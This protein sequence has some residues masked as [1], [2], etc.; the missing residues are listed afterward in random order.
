MSGAGGPVGEA[1]ATLRVLTYNVRSLRDDRCAVAALIRAARPDVA[2]IQEAPRFAHGRSRC[3][4]LAAGAGLVVVTGG[5]RAG[6]ML[7]LARLEVEVLDARDVLLTKAPGLHQRGLAIALLRVRG[8]RVVVASMHLD[9]VAAERLRHVPE[10][11]AHVRAA[12]APVVLAGD[13]NDDEG[14]PVWT[15]LTADLQDAAAAVDS[16]AWTG[17]GRRLDAVFASPSSTVKGAAVVADPRRYAA[18]D[19]WPLVVD[20]ELAAQ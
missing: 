4:A 12:G 18:S 16:R 1:P 19:H 15:A 14:S 2:C 6:A 3:A 17:P 5:R 9:V 11:L 10:V 20:L 13:V 7:L 8:A